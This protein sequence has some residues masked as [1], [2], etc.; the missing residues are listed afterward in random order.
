MKKA[1]LSLLLC[2]I[3]TACGSNSIHGD[4]VEVLQDPENGTVLIY[5]TGSG[6]TAAVLLEADTFVASFADGLSGADFESAPRGD[7]SIS[8]FPKGGR[9]SLKISGK[10]LKAYHTGTIMIHSYM[11][12]NAMTL[13]D[14]T[15][16]DVQHFSS[17]RTG[18]YLENGVELLWEATSRG[19]EKVHVIGL[20]NFDSLSEAAQ[21]SISS[22]YEEQGVLYDLQ[23]ELEHAYAAYLESGEPPDFDS[24]HVGQDVS[25]TASS[26]QVVYFQT[27]VTLPTESGNCYERRLCAAFDRETGAYIPM[28]GLF[29]CPEAEIG[30][31]LL[32]LSWKDGWPDDAPTLKQ[33]LLA[34][35][36]PEY[37]TISS[38]GLDITF[39]QGT[40]P[41]QQY[42]YG[43]GIDYNDGLCA[44]LYPWAVPDASDA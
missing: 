31:R 43:L 42:A 6:K 26:K 28:A 33:E 1:A 10:S 20:E 8:F 15:P 12:R 30:E 14:G 18:Y 9:T 23:A 3:L 11:T 4:V 34:A 19:P 17:G 37:V 27:T 13:A 41:S 44:I 25:P 29:S 5:E 2:L 40:L 35:F 36:Q 21:A 7:V 38:S 24:Y 39:P 32:A 16:L 22:F